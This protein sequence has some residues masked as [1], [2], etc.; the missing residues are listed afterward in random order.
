M[1]WLRAFALFALLVAVPFIVEALLGKHPRF[2]IGDLKLSDSFSHY[3]QSYSVVGILVL[4]LLCIA[5]FGF[6][7]IFLPQ[8]IQIAEWLKLAE[9]EMNALLR[10]WGGGYESRKNVVKERADWL[11]MIPVT[12]DPAPFAD[13]YKNFFDLNQQ[14]LT[15]GGSQGAAMGKVRMTAFL[16]REIYEGNVNNAQLKIFNEFANGGKPYIAPGIRQIVG[17]DQFDVNNVTN[18][19]FPPGAGVD[20]FPLWLTV[21]LN[22]FPRNIVMIR[23]DKSQVR[24]WLAIE[25]LNM[26]AAPA[27]DEPAVPVKVLQGWLDADSPLL[28]FL[29]WLVYL[30]LVALVGF[31]LWQFLFA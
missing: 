17:Y 20:W 23:A 24:N 16:L 21:V 6:L 19:G 1:A 29:R 27:R 11:G 14:D 10:A 26:Q 4:V 7:F 9:R 28:L 8:T 15:S 5:V 31:V 22:R 13:V 25:E 3:M 2:Q 30:S 18:N 12:D